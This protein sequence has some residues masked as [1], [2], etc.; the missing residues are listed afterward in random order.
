MRQRR[1]RIVIF[2]QG[3]G[4]HA[5]AY[6]ELVLVGERGGTS[7][8]HCDLTVIEEHPARSST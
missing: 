4:T 6:H 3:N 7:K 8:N 1:V 5:I 2:S